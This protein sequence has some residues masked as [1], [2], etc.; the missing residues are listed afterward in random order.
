[1]DR[2]EKIKVAITAGIAG[3][4]LLILV[5]YLA[6]SGN[7][8]NNK[9]DEALLD[10][11]ITEYAS[12]LNST[13][14]G[15]SADA[16]ASDTSQDLA[17]AGSLAAST[18]TNAGGNAIS[19]ESISGNCFYETTEPVLKDK[20][21]NVAFN[22]TNFLAEMLAYWD[23]N[24]GDAI[25]DLAH[26]E[27]YE[28]MSYSLKG[29]NNF[30]YYGETNEEGLPNGHGA[31][32]YANNQYY[33]GEWANGIRSGAGTW[34]AFY[35]DYDTYVVKEHMFSG[36]F[37]G[38]LPNGEGQEHY[39][40]NQQYMNDKDIYIQNAIGNFANG[41][42]DGEM[43]LITVNNNLEIKEWKGNCYKG[44]LEIIPNSS[45]DNKGYIPVFT[46]ME[47]SDNHMWMPEEKT[48]N[49]G[50]SGMISGGNLVK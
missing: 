1:M 13:D 41:L 29:T 33:F 9:E 10:E 37:A 42:Y 15:S 49:V 50:V 27:R 5:L 11:N 28:A 48:K 7:S 2:D 20:Y 40:Y 32:V 43:Y 8:G 39:D 4:I 44:T 14:A 36:E 34:F 35:P 23:A 16:S 47:N 30:Y 31:A 24:N 18:E 19:R 22:A 38:D 21:K 17:A 12:Q 26:L 3:V 45:K 46:N 6:L 25:R